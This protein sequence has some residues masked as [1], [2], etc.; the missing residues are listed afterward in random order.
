MAD[1]QKVTMAR[2]LVAYGKHKAGATIRGGLAAQLVEDGMA[3]AMKDT[4]GP[5]PKGKT[6]N[7][8]GAPENKGEDFKV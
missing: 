2:L 4:S 6:K 5:K 8:G 3:N 7:A 1:K